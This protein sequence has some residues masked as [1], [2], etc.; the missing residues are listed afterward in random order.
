MTELHRS[1]ETAAWERCLHA[2]LLPLE[3]K[4]ALGPG[5]LPRKEQRAGDKDVVC[6]AVACFS[7]NF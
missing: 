1:R 6:F 4:I 5:T 7:V 3:I 2:C